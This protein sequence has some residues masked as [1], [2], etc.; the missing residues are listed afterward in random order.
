MDDQGLDIIYVAHEEEAAEYWNDTLN[1]MKQW[2]SNLQENQS[3]VKHYGTEGGRSAAKINAALTIYFIGYGLSIICLSTAFFI[4][5]SYKKLRCSRNKIHSHL[6]MSFLLSEICWLLF[7]E[8][9]RHRTAKAG[10]KIISI[11]QLLAE[12]KQPYQPRPY[13]LSKISIC[14][15]LST[16]Y[17]YFHTTTFFWMFVEGVYLYQVL[18]IDIPGKVFSMKYYYIIGWGL[19]FAFA[20]IWYLTN[21][22]MYHHACVLI[23]KINLLHYI[24]VVPIFIVLLVKA[25]I[26]KHLKSCRE[27]KCLCPSCRSR[28]SIDPLKNSKIDSPDY[29][30]IVHHGS[31]GS[32]TTE[33]QKGCALIPLLARRIHHSDKNKN[34][35]Q[36]FAKSNKDKHSINIIINPAFPTNIKLV[37]EGSEEN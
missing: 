20:V 25:V 17:I 19:P 7:Y 10:H 16:F 27:S 2:T 23:L 35:K 1:P 8:V 36:K 4:L 22:I 5:L 34:S 32:A 31:I 26:W 6:I 30:P 18:I 11:S 14:N 24:Y 37:I 15:T 33:E 29:H 13:H 9:F 3:I 12:L 28:L 21:K